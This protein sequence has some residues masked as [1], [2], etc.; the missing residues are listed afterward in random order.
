LILGRWVDGREYR[1]KKMGAL[2]VVHRLIHNIRGY[3]RFLISKVMFK[4]WVVYLGLAALVIICMQVRVLC[5]RPWPIIFGLTADGTAPMA[6]DARWVSGSDAAFAQSGP[7]DQFPARVFVALESTPPWMA[8]EMMPESGGAATTNLTALDPK[9][10]PPPGKSAGACFCACRSLAH[11][12]PPPHWRARRSA[13][14]HPGYWQAE[15]AAT[16]GKTTMIILVIGA[17]FQCTK[18]WATL[19]N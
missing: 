3:G 8:S 1:R 7:Q 4:T 11:S 13:S 10:C 12:A 16:S 14:T 15:T 9:E 2:C 18:T 17:G 6:S 19:E 5:I